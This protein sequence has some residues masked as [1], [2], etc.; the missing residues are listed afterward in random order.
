M[1]RRL[2]DDVNISLPPKKDIV[3]YAGLSELQKKY[4]KA[5]LT[6]NAS[7]LGAKSRA[8]IAIC[9]QLRKCCNHPYLYLIVA[10]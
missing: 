9:I 5:I 10:T 7:V 4:Y 3:I 6:K 2:K 1:L 8:L